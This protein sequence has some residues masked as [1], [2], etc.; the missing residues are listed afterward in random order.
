VLSEVNTNVKQP[1][2]SEEV[3]GP[4]SAVPVNVPEKDPNKGEADVGPLYTL[5]TSYV[6]SVAN[7]VKTT[8]T[9]SPGVTGQIVVVPIAAVEL[10]L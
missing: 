6:A 5:K 7:E 2:A 9:K 3:N 8:V 4:G 1:D 10:G